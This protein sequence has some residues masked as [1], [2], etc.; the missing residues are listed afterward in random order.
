MPKKKIETRQ[1]TRW[2]GDSKAV[3]RDGTPRTLYH[4]TNMDF[5]AFDPTLSGSNQGM[6]LGDGLYLSTSSTAFASYGKNKL[7]MYV[8]I[9]KPFEVA[10]GLTKKQAVELND[11]LFLTSHSRRNILCNNRC[12]RFKI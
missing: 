4:Y 3:N 1:F 5:E 10:K 12:A 9:Q 11:T 6:R 2:F 8:S 7:E